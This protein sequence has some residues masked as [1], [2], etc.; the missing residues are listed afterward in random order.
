MEKNTEKF[1]NGIKILKKVAE[2]LLF[3]RH[4]SRAWAK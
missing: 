2:I 3:G 1:E 4:Y